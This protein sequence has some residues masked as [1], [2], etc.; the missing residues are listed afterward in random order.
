MT[1]YRQ[2]FLTTPEEIESLKN[3]IIGKVC[4]NKCGGNGAFL[5]KGVFYNCSCVIEFEK[6][7]RL[8]Q[9]NIPK[10]YWDFDLRNLTKEYS[11]GNKISLNIIKS[12]TS[13]IKE[14][15][16]KGIGLYVQGASGLAKT[17]LSYYILKEGIKQGV[18]C[19]SISM[20]RLTSLFFEISKE[21][22]KSRID[23]IV[24]DVDLL[25]IDE[26]EK[27]YNIDKSNTFIGAL[28]NDFFRSIYDKKKALII[29][30]NLSKKSLKDSKIHATN[31]IDRFEELVDIVLVGHSY[32]RQDENLKQIIG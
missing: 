21:D 7:L 16:E 27:D 17:A 4:K 11:D 28:V 2:S 14:M 26:I 12:Y 8:I 9:A 22:V 15:V 30:S 3:S 5:E 13:K 32:R 23:W 19:Y 6:R 1:L 24:N 25:V 18:V 10:K 29:T 31:V 20:S